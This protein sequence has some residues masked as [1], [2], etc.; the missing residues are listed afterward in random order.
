MANNQAQARDGRE[1]LSWLIVLGSD[2]VSGSSGSIAVGDVAVITGKAA[3][4][5]AFGD[6]PIGRYFMANA[7]LT[8]KEGDSCIKCT[9]AFLGQATGKSVEESKNVAD[10]TIDYDESTNSVTDGIVT[11]TGTISGALVTESLAS[12]TG[13]NLVKLRFGSIAEL[14]E[15]GTITYKEADTTAKDVLMIIWNARNAKVGD[16]LEVEIM[17]VLF[18]SV[19]KSGDYGSP[20]SFDVD[21]TACFT[22]DNNYSGMNLHVRCTE[23]LIAA[24]P[25]SRPTAG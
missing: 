6:I 4:E 17:P 11:K 3:S 14:D 20:Q 19:S 24:L 9:L 5:S 8:L 25:K 10:M 1:S 12:E 22:D 18:S 15:S 7:A 16:L 13:V 23:G 21:F 2:T